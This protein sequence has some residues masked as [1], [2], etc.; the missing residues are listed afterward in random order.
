M[1]K[2][3]DLAIC[4]SMGIENYIKETYKKYKPNTTYIAYGAN[5]DDNSKIDEKKI[6]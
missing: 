4:D 3:C 6:K 5:I 1:I 2:N